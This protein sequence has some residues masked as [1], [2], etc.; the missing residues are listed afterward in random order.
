MFVQQLGT[1]LALSDDNIAHLTRFLSVG[2]KHELLSNRNALVI[3][4]GFNTDLRLQG[5][6]V[7]AF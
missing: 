3:K 2:S 6:L 1:Q 5:T 7:H 4:H